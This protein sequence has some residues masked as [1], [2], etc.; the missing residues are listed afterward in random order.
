G[1]PRAE[2]A[3]VLMRSGAA[4]AVVNDKGAPVPRAVA[5]SRERPSVHRVARGGPLSSLAP[6][7]QCS[8]SY[9][10]PP[11]PPTPAPHPLARA[12]G[13]Q[14]PPQGAVLRDPHRPGHQARHLQTVGARANRPL[15]SGAP[16]NGLAQAG[17]RREPV[18]GASSSTS[19]SPTVPS[20]ARPFHDAEP[21]AW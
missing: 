18:H 17:T 6:Q 19:M 12:P 8:P 20:W 2:L 10:A 14:Q 5:T 4:V 16:R 3:Q 1:G 9:L 11:H 15:A 7:D 21:S 13:P